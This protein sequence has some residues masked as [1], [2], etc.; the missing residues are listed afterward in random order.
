MVYLRNDEQTFD[1]QDFVQSFLQ[2]KEPDCILY[3][4]EGTKFDVHTEILIQSEL[5]KNV[6]LSEKNSWH[7]QNIEIYM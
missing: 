1:H 2:N 7:Y 5:M 6:L 4:K 3:S